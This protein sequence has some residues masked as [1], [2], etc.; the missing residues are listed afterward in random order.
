[1]KFVS[2]RVRPGFVDVDRICVMRMGRPVRVARM[3]RVVRWW[4]PENW[5]GFWRISSSAM[6]VRV[7]GLCFRSY[8]GFWG[9]VGVRLLRQC[10]NDKRVADNCV[11]YTASSLGE[12]SAVGVFQCPA[13]V[14]S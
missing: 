13:Q 4:C 8:V 11:T 12:C 6:V 3:R 14:W 5:R 1:M 2:C 10:S 9:G 7:L